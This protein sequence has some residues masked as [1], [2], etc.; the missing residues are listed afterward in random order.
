MLAIA[1]ALVAARPARAHANL[2]AS[3]PAAGAVLADAPAAVVLDFTETLDSRAAGVELRDATGAVVAGPGVIDPAQA[4]RL[5]L[6]LPA[7]AD[8]TYIAA[9]RVRSAV[10]GH[11]TEGTVP[12]SVG[13]DA[14]PPSIIAPPG[15]PEP[16]TALPRP[17]DALVRWLNFLAASLA[18]GSLFFGPLVWRPA[19]GRMEAATNDDDRTATTVLRH[20][21]LAGIAAWGVASL[22][23]VVIQA[24]QLAPVPSLSTL[25]AI[26]GGRTG[27]LVAIRLALL[28]AAG[29]LALRLP[30]A[31]GGNPTPWVVASLL[32]AA[33]LM[34]ISLQSHSAAL[35]GDRAFPAIVNDWLH[36]L[37]MAA[38]LGGL[39]GLALL[40]RAGWGRPGWAAALIPR[41]T[42][43]ALPAVAL[44]ALTGFISSLLN[45]RTVEALLSTTH[46]RSLVA[47]L[48]LFAGLLALGA[49]NLFLLSP[50]LR[51]REDSA[52]RGL[53]RTV[54]VEII[55]GLAVLAAVGLMTAV[56]PAYDA[57]EAQRRLGFSESARLDDVRL[58][59]RVAPLQVG[60][61][62][63]AVDVI[64]NRPG[65]DAAEPAVSLRFD[66]YNWHIDTF[67]VETEPVGGGRYLA[68]GAHF[69][70]PGDWQIEV[71]LR[72]RGFDDVRHTFDMIV[73]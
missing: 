2:A 14:L 32:T 66:N 61:N 33:A 26:L 57:L 64:D 70:I 54:R 29:L 37:A 69:A 4:T 24:W 42:W 21:A 3:E 18:A 28:V 9:W 25:G 22:L 50:R 1:W 59:L 71:I 43:V 49:A 41:F 60:D 53:G 45:V 8:G 15:T 31:G 11:I 72:Q 34:T 39:P 17:A 44:L 16:A 65:A 58:T 56:A 63:F 67:Q 6:D 73:E 47:K 36:L 19:F 40:L 46:G 52:A 27:V 51:R 68:R 13:A 23:F 48:A 62:E 38:W 12:F 55:L 20:L 35:P 7:L 5:R 10:D 30:P